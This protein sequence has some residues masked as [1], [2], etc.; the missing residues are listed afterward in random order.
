MPTQTFTTSGSWVAP[1]GV[2]SVQVECWGPGGSGGAFLPAVP[3]NPN[4]KENESQPAVFGLGGGGGAYAKT[5]AASVTPGNTYIISVGPGGTSIV[6]NMTDGVSITYAQA[7]AG[8][9]GSTGA[10]GAGGA[11][12]ACTGDVKISGNNG[13]GVDGGNGA[14]GGVG[15]SVHNNGIAPGGGGG[16]DN[17]GTGSGTGARGQV[18]LTWTDP[19]LPAVPSRSQII[20]IG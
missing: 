13:S 16:G 19:A 20:Y 1:T 4:T 2:T 12:A 10:A 3:D 11:A 14:N 6:S 15:G 5:N 8:Q 9:A 7:V 17:T 18:V